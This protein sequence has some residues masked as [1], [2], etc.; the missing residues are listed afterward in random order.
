MYEVA[1]WILLVVYEV[2]CWILLENCGASTKLPVEFSWRLAVYE[3]ACWFL[4]VACAAST[5]LRAPINS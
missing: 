5:I 2:A 1:C 3:V 4:S